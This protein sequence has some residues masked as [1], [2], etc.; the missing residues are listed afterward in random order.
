MKV[1]MSPA[2]KAD[3]DMK[4]DD[5]TELGLPW[6]GY[7]SVRDAYEWDPGSWAD[8]VPEQSVPG[9]EAPPWRET[10]EDIDDVESMAFPRMAG[11][12]EL[13]WSLPKDFRGTNT[14]NGS[15][16]RGRAGTRCL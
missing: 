6:A 9:P 13:G 4:Y 10:L 5:N 16:H 7:P 12:A 2:E 14:G 11:I 1:V 3:I 15:A 8:G